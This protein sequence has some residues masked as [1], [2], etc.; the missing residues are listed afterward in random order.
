L[1]VD[2]EKLIYYR[3]EELITPNDLK[4][5]RKLWGDTP[6]NWVVE[7]PIDHNTDTGIHDVTE[8][9]YTIW[10]DPKL[11]K[12]SDELINRISKGLTRSKSYGIDYVEETLLKKLVTDAVDEFNKIS[13]E[14]IERYNF[15]FM[16]MKRLYNIPTKNGVIHKMDESE[17]YIGDIPKPETTII[18]K[19]TLEQDQCSTYKKYYVEGKLN[20]KFK[21]ED[22]SMYK[23]FPY[24]GKLYM[25]FSGKEYFQLY[26]YDYKNR[27]WAMQN[28]L[29]YLVKN[30]LVELKY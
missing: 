14:K 13:D 11:N 27:N 17:S 16:E 25:G 4:R 18:A 10:N 12:R 22:R 2:T 28:I 8:I 24:L 23:M 6:Y 20:Y 7:L 15:P 9:L 21:S 5:M 1:I 26:V 3:G 19:Y 30:D 29:N